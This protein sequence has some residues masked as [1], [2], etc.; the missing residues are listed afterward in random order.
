MFLLRFTRIDANCLSLKTLIIPALQTAGHVRCHISLIGQVSYILC[1]G[2]VRVPYY[3]ETLT[4]PRRKGSVCFDITRRRS[5]DRSFSRF[6]TIYRVCE[7]VM[8]TLISCLRLHFPRV[9]YTSTHWTQRRYAFKPC[10][11]ELYLSCH[12][13]DILYSR[14]NF[15]SNFFLPKCVM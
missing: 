14:R 12:F 9:V 7:L 11:D 2:R 15:Q 1:G 6:I 4:G 3:R 10:S 8:L 13:I 5:S